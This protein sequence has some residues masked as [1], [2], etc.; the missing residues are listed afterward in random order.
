MITFNSANSVKLEKLLLRFKLTLNDKKKIIQESKKDYHTLDSL[1]R[2]A[3]ELEAKNEAEAKKNQK[4]KKVSNYSKS[5]A[6]K[7]N[8]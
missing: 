8:Q 7:F 1:E 3:R 6:K 5:Y 2:I 4:L